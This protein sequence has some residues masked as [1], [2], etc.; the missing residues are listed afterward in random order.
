MLSPALVAH[1]LDEGESGQI[2]R[3]NILESV[4]FTA[5]VADAETGQGAIEAVEGAINA[6]AK[7]CE[8][9]REWKFHI[10]ATDCGTPPQVSPT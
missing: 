2:C 1:D 4:P 3:F 5:R 9:S 8:E 10:Q 6:A 7:D